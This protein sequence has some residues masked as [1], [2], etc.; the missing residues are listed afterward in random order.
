M[1]GITSYAAQCYK[2][3][4]WYKVLNLNIEIGSLEQQCV[5]IKLLYQSDQLKKH[6]VTIEIYQLLSNSTMYKHICLENIKKL[7]TSSV[8]CD[9]QQHYKDII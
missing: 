6:N 2:S 5:I 1:D 8:K 9:N 4:S 7:Y 3:R